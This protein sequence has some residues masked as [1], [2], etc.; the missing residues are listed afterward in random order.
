MAAEVRA[1]TE[2]RIEGTNE[3]D[4]NPKIS[5]LN[6]LKL[7]GP[8]H[9]NGD[10]ILSRQSHPVATMSE[11]FHRQVETAEGVA[12]SDD[13]V[14]FAV[15]YD[16]L[17]EYLSLHRLATEYLAADREYRTERDKSQ[18]GI[19]VTLK[20]NKAEAALRAALGVE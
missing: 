15:S 9:L 10:T 19:G 16:L 4:M 17:Q 3:R 18:A 1:E 20:A 13:A 2:I 6:P 14:L 12:T 8:Y 7:T 11:P 5:N